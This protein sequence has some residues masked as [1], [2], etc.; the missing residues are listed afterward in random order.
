M[1]QGGAGLGL[2]GVNQ[3]GWG[4]SLWNAPAWLTA[5]PAPPPASAPVIRPLERR[6]SI[7]PQDA[8]MKTLLLLLAALAVAAGPGEGW[9]R[10]WRGVACGPGTGSLRC[11]P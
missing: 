1:L 9:R 3:P 8:A 10:A 4:R 6:G 7:A 2:E 11:G 5:Y